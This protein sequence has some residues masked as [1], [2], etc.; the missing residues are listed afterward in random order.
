M[1]S[2]SISGRP[3]IMQIGIYASEPCLLQAAHPSARPPEL[4]RTRFRPGR[5]DT[6]A[7]VRLVTFSAELARVSYNRIMNSAKR[8]MAKNT[9]RLNVL[10]RQI[11]N[12]R[13]GSLWRILSAIDT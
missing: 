8:H 9:Y 13:S 10:T 2:D 11:S 5:A 1:V 7:P 3:A 4:S 12:Q 6:P